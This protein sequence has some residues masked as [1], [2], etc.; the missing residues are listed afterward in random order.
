MYSR[1]ESKISFTSIFGPIV[2]PTHIPDTARIKIPYC[3]QSK[4]R[5]C[6][7]LK[8]NLMN[9]LLTLLFLNEFS[10]EGKSKM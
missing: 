2:T 8:L 10:G 7:L 9:F 4:D 5:I 1:R 6:K 3:T